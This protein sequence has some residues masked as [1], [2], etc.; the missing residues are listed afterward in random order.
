M[1]TRKIASFFFF[2]PSHSPHRDFMKKGRLTRAGGD[3]ARKI[4]FYDPQPPKTRSY[5]EKSTSRW[6]WL[7]QKDRIVTI[8]Q[9]TLVLGRR[10]RKGAVPL[11]FLTHRPHPTAN[12]ITSVPRQRWVPNRGNQTAAPLSSGR[13]TGRE[14]SFYIETAHSARR[15]P[16][17]DIACVLLAQTKDAKIVCVIAVGPDF[18]THNLK[19]LASARHL[20][21]KTVL[22]PDCTLQTNQSVKTKKLMMYPPGG[23]YIVARR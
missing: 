5:A 9:L 17:K 18:S 12:F 23:T 8:Q 13:G 19:R 2:T 15:F 21:E 20:I 6:I 7:C 4:N 11:F 10:A 1:N 22:L 3:L 16:L 14:R